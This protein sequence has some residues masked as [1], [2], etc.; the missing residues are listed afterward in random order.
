MYISVVY[1]VQKMIFADALKI[2][3]VRRVLTKGKIRAVLCDTFGSRLHCD[4]ASITP[5]FVMEIVKL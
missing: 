5:V 2:N 1:L 4:H 3:Y